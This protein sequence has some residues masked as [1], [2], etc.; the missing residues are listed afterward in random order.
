M[1]MRL[2]K[3][4]HALLTGV[5]R[6]GDIAV[7]AT[8]GN[9]HDTVFLS[10]LLGPTG[11]VFAFDVQPDALRATAGRLAASACG[12]NVTLTCACHSAMGAHI[13]VAYHGIVTAV[14]LNLGYLPGSDRSVMTRSE[15][16]VRAIRV[17]FELLRVGG[18]LTV[19][20]YPGHSGGPEETAAAERTLDALIGREWIRRDLPHESPRPRLLVIRRVGIPEEAASRMI[21]R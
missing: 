15:T 5:L 16:T 17:G 4:V 9:G 2:T 19:L 6:E 11:H 8:M 12:D 21:E 1:T 20:A 7:D 13:P 10:Q 18:I 14:V 3:Q